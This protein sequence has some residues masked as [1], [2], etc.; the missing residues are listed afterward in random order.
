MDIKANSWV[1]SRKWISFSTCL[2]R[3]KRGGL[4]LTLG[5]GRGVGENFRP[6]GGRGGTM[7]LASGGMIVTGSR[8]E[9]ARRGSGG[10]SIVCTSGT[11]GCDVLNRSCFAKYR[12]LLVKIT[13]PLWS[14]MS[15]YPS[16]SD[17]NKVYWCCSLRCIK[18]LIRCW[19][20]CVRN[21]KL[22]VDQFN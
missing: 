14:T 18:G 3:R 9:S 12:Y 6:S 21:P 7:C 5:Y 4:T 8:T 19:F 20:I 11:V 16:I 13:S 10:N 1:I 2:T 15:V 17:L 22:K